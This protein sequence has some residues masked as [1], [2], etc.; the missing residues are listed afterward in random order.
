M[1]AGG[2]ISSVVEGAGHAQEGQKT[3]LE[4]LKKVWTAFESLLFGA[5]LNDG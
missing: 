1:G 3:F 5:L 2:E 4:V